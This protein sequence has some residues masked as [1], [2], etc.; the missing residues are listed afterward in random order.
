MLEYTDPDIIL[1]SETWL[2]PDITERELLP[3][4]YR[5]VARKDRKSDP[6]GGVAIIAKAEFDAVEIELSTKTEFVAASFACKNLKQPL[7]VGSVYRP[8]DNNYEYAEDLRKAV[9]H[10]G[11]TYKNSTIWIGGDF[12]LPDIDWKTN[13][14]VSHNYPIPISKSILDMIQDLGAEQMVDFPTRKDS[15]LDIFVTNRPS[16]VNKCTPIP[17]LSDHD[18]VLIDANIVPSRQKPARRLIYLWNKANLIEMEQDI[19]AF[20]RSFTTE[21]SETTPINT[22]WDIFKKKVHG[23]TSKACPFQVHLH[24]IQSILVQ[25]HNTTIV[26]E[27]KKSV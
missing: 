17:G 14:L 25:P 24:Q 4:N 11:S 6:H 27:E 10:I 7:V 3:D 15:I 1:A 13:S 5:F 2:Y 16:L 21:H 20:S 23:S 22:L 18:I 8:T 19:A 26:A 12:N 9:I